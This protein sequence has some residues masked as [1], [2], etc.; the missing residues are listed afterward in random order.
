M[1]NNDLQ[2]FTQ[3]TTDRATQTQLNPLNYHYSLKIKLFVQIDNEWPSFSH[4][5]R[6]CYVI[7]VFL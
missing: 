2:N 1:T 6:E 4:Y 5:F 3:K 7:I